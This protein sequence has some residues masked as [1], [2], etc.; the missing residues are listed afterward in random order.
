MTSGAVIFAFNSETTDYLSMA[1][2]SAWRIKKYLGLPTT[3]ITD[4]QDVDPKGFDRI[5]FVD[6]DDVQNDRWFPD[7][8]KVTP[9]YNRDRCSAYD[10]SPYDRSILLDA[11]YVV[12]SDVLSC[13]VDSSRDFLCHAR[14]FD[15]ARGIELD[16][17]NRFGRHAMPMLWATVIIFSKSK[18]SKH[19]FD[20]M[21]MVRDHWQHYRNIYGI[22]QSIF[23]NDYALTIAAGIVSGHTGKIDTIPWAL[24][25]IMPEVEI[26]VNTNDPRIFDYRYQDSK[27]RAKRGS[28]TSQDFHAMNKHQLGDIVARVD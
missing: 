27:L 16:N 23:R 26:S 22:T 5:L 2:W 1:R 4:V 25:T 3:V 7:T 24:P 12:N 13:V 11:D 14:A 9:W 20:C 17:L 21:K 18:F 10:L 28:I 6:Q 8:K 19:I 15:V